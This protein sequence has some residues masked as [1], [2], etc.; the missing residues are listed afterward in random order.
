MI[1]LFRQIRQELVSE[2]RLSRY[3]LY[4]LG[5]IV[6]V[7]IGILIALQIN[8]WN[9]E[10]IRVHREIVIL[11]EI[12]QDLSYDLENQVIPGIAYC[13]VASDSYDYLRSNYYQSLSTVS[14]DST[15]ALFFKVLL[16]WYLTLNT[17]AFDN[18]NSIG[19]DLISNDSL[20]EQIS[21]FYGYEYKFLM[22]YQHYT[23]KW[24]RE[25]ILPLVSDNVNLFTVLSKSELD[26]LRDDQ[27]FTTRLRSYT[28]RNRGFRDHLVDLKPKGEQLIL[29]INHEVERLED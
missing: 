27:R 9:Q 24:F 19:I 21:S 26:F 20:R 6:L 1:N 13:E 16:P 15:R 25:D 23:E 29:N 10:K 8:N 14:D 5:E 4:A 17:V 28:T 11:K 18:L 12:S 2:N 22:K 7:V 3:L